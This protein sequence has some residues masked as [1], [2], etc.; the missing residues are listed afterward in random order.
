[1]MSYFGSLATTGT[2]PV[3]IEKNIGELKGIVNK[4]VF[5]VTEKNN[6]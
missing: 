4:A 5:T 1:M 6:E 2:P 3:C